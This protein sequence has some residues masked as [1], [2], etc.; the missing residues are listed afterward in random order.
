M[1]RLSVRYLA[2]TVP[3]VVMLSWVPAFGGRASATVMASQ[4]SKATC[5][6]LPRSQ[7]QPLLAVPITKLKVTSGTASGQNCVYLGSGGAAIDVLVIKGSFAKQGFQEDVKGMSS[8]VPVSGVGDKAY[9]EK[10]DFQIDSIKG[11]EYC[12]VSV[13]S[14]DDIPGVSALLVNGSSDIPESDNAII[15]SALGTICNRF[16]GKGNTKP[17]LKGLT[18][19]SSAAAGS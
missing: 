7:I 6:Q 11:S 3:I 15:A 10:G 16:Y 12:S 18:S 4:S 1:L 19:L 13:G 8:K 5:K 17:S 2:L 14:E 9:R